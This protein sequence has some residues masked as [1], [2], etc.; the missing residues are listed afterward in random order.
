MKKRV[1]KKENLDGIGV[2]LLKATQIT[3]AE[4]EKIINKP[5][6]FDSVVARIKAEDIN[7]R[8]KP[9]YGR[10]LLLSSA[11]AIVIMIVG[12]IFLNRPNTYKENQLAQNE[13]STKPQIA[14]VFGENPRTGS[15]SIDN[16][17]IVKTTLRETKI[18]RQKLNSNRQ[19]K[20]PKTSL[21]RKSVTVPDS[22]PVEQIYAD[23][24][25]F[26]ALPFA[27]DSAD[28][29]IT[30][31]VRAELSRAE[32]SALGVDLPL[33]EENEDERILTDLI[34]GA[35]GNPKAFRLVGKL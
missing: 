25:K 14:T 9:F 31:F 16:K 33:T 6:L 3:D 13:T 18:T 8:Q 21:T 12:V 17:S 28:N 32:L 27:D 15:P 1:L 7:Q 10:R 4:I 20:A 29:K 11:A 35:N 2:N 23:E 26:Y 34:Y 24:G 19:S 22:L 30:Q 5:Q